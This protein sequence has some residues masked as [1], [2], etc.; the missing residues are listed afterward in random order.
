MVI[1]QDLI[2]VGPGETAPGLKNVTGT[3]WDVEP[4]TPPLQREGLVL[5]LDEGGEMVLLLARTGTGTYTFTPGSGD[6]TGIPELD[7]DE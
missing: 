3:L 7:H 4:S 1:T 5:V 6:P 2:Y